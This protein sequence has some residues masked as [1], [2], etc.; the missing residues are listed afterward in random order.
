MCFLKAE[1][2][3]VSPCKVIPTYNVVGC[4]RRGGLDLESVKRENP[5]P[6]RSSDAHRSRDGSSSYGSRVSFPI[7]NKPR[8][9][10]LRKS[11]LRVHVYRNTERDLA[12]SLYSVIPEGMSFCSQFKQPLEAQQNSTLHT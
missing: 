5:V 8:H 9:L 7:T 4:K 11:S 3:R 10:R 1:N 6:M 12:V 2:I